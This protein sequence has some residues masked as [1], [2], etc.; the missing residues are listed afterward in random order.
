M[1]RHRHH[2]NSNTSDRMRMG[3]FVPLNSRYYLHNGEP[4]YL[5][6]LL[7]Q[8]SEFRRHTSGNRAIRFQEKLDELNNEIR[9]LD[10]T[11]LND[12]D[13]T[14]DQ[15]MLLFNKLTYIKNYYRN[16]LSIGAQYVRTYWLRPN[17]DYI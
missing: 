11:L 15:C 8:H 5:S 2:M 16:L 6:G 7:H 12:E 4:A 10:E 13:I 9:I 3:R 17:G 14:E 1:P